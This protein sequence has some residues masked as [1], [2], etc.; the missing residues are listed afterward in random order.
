M[1]FAV[2]ILYRAVN[3][4]LMNDRRGYDYW[5]WVCTLSNY[6]KQEPKQKIFRL[7]RDSNRDLCDLL[8]RIFV[9][10]SNF[11][12]NVILSFSLE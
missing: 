10:T 6:E 2:M 3:N 11:I 1:I 5:D 12:R 8:F 7:Q 4:D 9:L